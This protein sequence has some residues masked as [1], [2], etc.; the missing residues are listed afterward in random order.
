MGVVSLEFFW[1]GHL[2]WG[3]GQVALCSEF[4]SPLYQAPGLI[5]LLVSSLFDLKSQP[6][7]LSSDSIW[8]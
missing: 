7:F 3:P 6:L 1:F 2:Q 8:E 5:G 4:C